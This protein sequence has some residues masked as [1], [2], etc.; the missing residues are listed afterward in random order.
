MYSSQSI[1]DD[2][3]CTVGIQQR[4][5]ILHF[6]VCPCKHLNPC[7]HLNPFHI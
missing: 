3:C 5:H 4:Q 6:R 1:Y 2:K 7:I